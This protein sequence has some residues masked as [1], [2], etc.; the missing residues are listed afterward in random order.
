MTPLLSP[1]LTVK[2]LPPARRGRGSEGEEDK[3]ILEEC[4][5]R[6]ERELAFARPAAKDR[7]IFAFESSFYLGSDRTRTSHL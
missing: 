3:E 5:R 1:E 6:G 4:V 7:L 2:W